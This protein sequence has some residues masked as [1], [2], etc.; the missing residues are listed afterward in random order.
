[1]SLLTDKI[2]Q[3]LTLESAQILSTYEVGKK[4]A[5]IISICSQKGGVG[6]TTTAVNLGTAFVKFFNKRVLVLDLDPQGH[7]EKSLGS[8]IPEGV[9]Y[10]PMSTLLSHKKGNVLDGVIATELDNFYLSPGDK[11]LYETESLLATKIGKEFILNDA[12]KDARTQFDFILIDCPPNLGNLTL[13]SLVASDYCIVPCEMSV[14]AFEGVNDLV[15]TLETVNE[16]L[17]KQLRILGVLF[18]RVDGRNINMNQVVEDNIQKFFHGKIFKTQI[19]INT[20]LNKAQLEGLP[21]FD[22]HPSS[23]GAQNYKDLAEEVLQKLKRRIST[24]ASRVAQNGV[25][26]AV[27]A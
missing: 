18:T 26:K 6:K 22:A 12:L 14:L 9:E 1:M 20:A 3:L 16:R 17:N 11:T 10:S 5:V 23:S 25:G 19:A 13:N 27:N 8:L 15:E 2:K 24:P 4:K 21:V 7:I